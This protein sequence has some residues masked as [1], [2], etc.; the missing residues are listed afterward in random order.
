SILSLNNYYL[1][2]ISKI[3]AFSDLVGK[4]RNY[5]N[6]NI[7]FATERIPNLIHKNL[8]E[9]SNILINDNH[10]SGLLDF[11]W[12]EAA[13]NEYELSQISMLINEFKNN[14]TKKV[15][16]KSFL[17]NYKFPLSRNFNAK[18]RFYLFLEKIHFMNIWDFIKHKYSQS[19]AKKLIEKTRK[20]II[21]L[22]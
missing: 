22:N 8:Y 19:Q 7:Q 17:E 11:E 10:I 16:W 2:K 5:L 13:D 3:Q 20:F 4:C 9:K 18:K 15:F 6:D 12:A 14:G 1:N 21:E